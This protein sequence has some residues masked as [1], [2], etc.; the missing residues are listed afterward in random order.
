MEQLLIWSLKA[1]IIC[2]LLFLAYWLL[3]RNNSRA[4][5]KRGILLIVL[6]CT[7]S[8]PL[9]RV[10]L[11]LDSFRPQLTQI[12]P[13]LDSESTELTVDK[14]RLEQA[15]VE[16]PIAEPSFNWWKLAMN[17]YLAGILVSATLLALEIYRL[18][19]LKKSGTKGSILNRKVIFH[20]RIH[21]PFSFMKWI[22]LPDGANYN[23]DTWKAIK[24]HEEAHIH[25]WHT[26]DLLTSRILLILCWYNPFCYWLSR[27]IKLNH[28]ALADSE[29]LKSISLKTYTQTLLN[30]SLAQPERPLGHY[31]ALKSSLSARLILM[32]TQKTNTMKTV[33]NVIAF[34]LIG[35]LAFLQANI[36][37]QD[38]E[39]HKEGMFHNG[40]LFFTA[41]GDDGSTFSTIKIKD[42]FEKTADGWIQNYA[43]SQY[44]PI[45]LTKKRT[46]IIT[47]ISSQQ[48]DELFLQSTLLKLSKTREATE[49]LESPI[50]SINNKVHTQFELT[51]DEL[52]AMYDL[53]KN[54]FNNYVRPIYP[55]QK[56]ISEPEFIKY[57]YMIILSPDDEQFPFNSDE[58]VLQVSEVDQL[59]SPKGGLE[60]FLTNILKEASSSV[61]LSVLDED[62]AFNLVVG[63]NG[64]I[65]HLELAT[66]V[67][68]DEATQ[69]KK[70]EALGAI[71]KQILNL[72]N[73]YGWNS[74]KK[75]NKRVATNYRLEIPKSSF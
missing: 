16:P 37:G 44:I 52:V 69:D 64:A 3:F 30:I 43:A 32:K 31:M 57:K 35:T 29:T 27:N 72:S 5:L 1:S 25:Q 50:I 47:A 38:K 40:T 49:L 13:A 46:D 18:F 2:S 59:P 61:D 10:E 74:A 66:E 41:D 22:F 56:F 26:A 4:Q 42:R 7:V 36:Y 19:R 8:F 33:R 58:R 14:L 15:Q 62:V 39:S 11:K 71:N 34:S 73:L 53:S 9:I 23:S 65:S 68:G 60:R 70:F 63:I 51:T 20:K 54:W 24:T 21:S 48:D 12:I 55:E 45:I 67:I 6:L 75:A 17:L 28:E